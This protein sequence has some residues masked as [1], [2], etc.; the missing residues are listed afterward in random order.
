VDRSLRQTVSSDRPSFFLPLALALA[1]LLPFSARAAGTV[2][3][4]ELSRGDRLT[5][6]TALSS[7]GVRTFELVVVGIVKGTAPG[8]DLIV[9][10]ALGDDLA[11]TGIFQGMS[12]SPVYLD[13][14]LV[15]AVSS[16]WSFSKKPMA[17]VTPI[18]NML[19]LMD[20]GSR[21]SGAGFR[22][23]LLRDLLPPEER[24]ASRAGAL[25]RRADSVEGALNRGT[26]VLGS[27]GGRDI[28]TLG[29]PLSVSGSPAFRE[30]IAPGLEAMGFTPV[31]AP[32]SGA[33]ARTD[34]V[35]PGSPI[36][37]QLVGGDMRWTASGTV[38]H[39]DGD[40]ILAFGHPLF[41]SGP[42]EMPL[43]AAEAIDVV[44]LQSVSFR[45]TRAGDV[46]GTLVHDGATG[47]AGVLGR[48][49]P[50]IP[51]A[52]SLTG[53]DVDA[54]F[55]LDVVAARPYAFLFSSLAAA[56][57]VSE[58]YRSSGRV[59][60][61]LRVRIDT[62]AETV[63]YRDVFATVEPAIRLGSEL[64]MLLTVLGDSGLAERT[65]ESVSVDADFVEDWGWYAIER[66]S[67]ER[68]VVAPG[69]EIVLHALLRPW[70]G[71]AVRRELRLPVPASAD[72]GQLIVRVGGAAAYHE[73]DAERLGAGA[74]PRTY[75][76]LVRLVETS[77]PGS[78]LAAQALSERRSLT[79]EG[80]EI[81]SLPGRA[82]LAM[83]AG[84]SGGAG[85]PTEAT[86]VSES[87]VELDDE[88]AGY[89]EIIVRVSR[90][91]ER[92]SASR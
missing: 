13:D 55:D 79:V 91:A 40:T 47:V 19:D 50:T 5:G 11:E 83:G 59:T 84:G 36:G 30:R 63:R 2:S 23:D 4:D 21:T 1:M 48:T 39:R 33:D 69:G 25:A 80:D 41:E 88:V 17:A 45:L 74:A 54:A 49:P 26:H 58:V 32:A 92:S 42:T 44:P 51:V 38:T 10:R 28:T 85:V 9:A 18:G 75:A 24:A 27:F 46:I 90:E 3:A 29:T 16:A 66:V 76:Q 7:E 61:E 82:A 78:V 68:A 31:A 72:E 52:L 56:G 73:W 35:G 64:S 37:V 87:F 65:I 53:P 15:G 20:G 12:G 67:A 8:R 43:V 77:K 6:L 89:H 62:N 86:V 22:C 60:V 71:D 57:A 14:R 70:R 81:G 34:S